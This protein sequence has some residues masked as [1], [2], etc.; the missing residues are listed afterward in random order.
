[1]RKIKVAFVCHFSNSQIREFLPLKN[2]KVRNL[3][4]R[5]LG[6]SPWHH[7][8]VAIWVDDFVN[9]FKEHSDEIELHT[10]SPHHGLKR[11]YAEFC[12]DGVY[13]HFYKT[14]GN[15][16]EDLISAKTKRKERNNYKIDSIRSSQIIK[17]INPDI[18]CL[19]GAENP[20][21]GSFIFRIKDI[22]V[23]LIP[24]TFLNDPKRIEM[25]VASDYRVQ[26]EKEV[27]KRINYLSSTKEAIQAFAKS[28]NPIIQFYPIPF[29]SHQPPV[30]PIKNKEYDFVFY[31]KVVMKN[32][33]IEDVLRALA[34]VVKSYPKAKLNV[35]GG[36]ET[37]Y[38]QKLMELVREEGV[39][40]NVNFSGQYDLIEDVYKNVQKGKVVVI[41]GI[42]AA[43]NSTVRES[44]FM[45][46][47]VIVYSS[48]RA[49]EINEKKQC[50]FIAKMEDVTDLANKMILSLNDSYLTSEIANNA[51]QY[52]EDEFGNSKIGSLLVKNI[53]TI[54]NE[55]TTIVN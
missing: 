19:C 44:M 31:A 13:Y 28:C 21:Y 11:K 34:L 10:I 7:G 52:A 33:G 12:K 9:M 39:E 45:G 15:L 4:L 47:P 54:V 5:L 30:F 1:M 35:I 32:K 3:V 6:H 48:A 50:L 26:F 43:L 42:T 25:H 53:K 46:M 40:R 55:K 49:E 51:R 29:P 36:C 2:W 17:R 23:Y 27:Y 8:D 16:I 41:P 18:I 20:D 24:Q 37:S 14:D 38:K 22:P